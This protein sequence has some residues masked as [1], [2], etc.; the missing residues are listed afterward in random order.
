MYTQMCTQKDRAVMLLMTNPVL[1]LKPAAPV[2]HLILHPF[3]R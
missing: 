1:C 3:L 2:L